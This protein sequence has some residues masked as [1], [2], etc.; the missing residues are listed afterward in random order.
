MLRPVSEAEKSGDGWESRT[1]TDPKVLRALAHPLRLKLI[2]ELSLHGPATATQ[3]A[4]RFGESP[5]NCS[6]HLRQL[7][8]YGYVVE[9]PGGS[10]R[11][12]PWQASNR[13]NEWDSATTDEEFAEAGRA[14]SDVITRWEFDALHAY[15]NKISSDPPE[16]REASFFSQT[17]VWLTAEELAEIGREVGEVFLRHMRRH[18]HPDERPATARAVRL[19]AWGV[20][21]MTGEEQ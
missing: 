8:R 2:E 10:G 1:I 3:L 14:A 9:A 11:N 12:R 6:W 21:N 15:W 17:L 4:E 13:G 18:N 5:A 7:A 20:P 16:W 19:V